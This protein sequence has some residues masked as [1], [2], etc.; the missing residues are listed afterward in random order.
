MQLLQCVL[1]V[2]GSAAQNIGSSTNSTS[3][4]AK[5]APANSPQPLPSPQSETCTAGGRMPCSVHEYAR[6]NR[7]ELRTLTGGRAAAGWAVEELLAVPVAPEDGGWDR[8]D[9]S[10]AAVTADAKSRGRP[11]IS[12]RSSASSPL[13][14]MPRGEADIDRGHAWLH[15]QFKTNGRRSR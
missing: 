5:L 12:N 10:S 9:A 15:L 7:S 14:A 4:A 3:L 8:S 11:N 2:S 1:A 13:H 6:E